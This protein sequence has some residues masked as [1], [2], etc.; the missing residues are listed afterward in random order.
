M[1]LGLDPPLIAAGW[2]LPK[3]ARSLCCGCKRRGGRSRQLEWI[4]SRQPWYLLLLGL[5]WLSA[6]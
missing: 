4:A 6:T 5:L 1:S 3:P 2:P